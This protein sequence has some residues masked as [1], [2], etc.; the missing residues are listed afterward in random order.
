MTPTDLVL[1][2]IVTVSAIVGLFRGLLREAIAVFTWVAALWFAWHFGPSL[3]PSLGGALADPSVRPWA[4]R[5]IIFVGVLF[6]GAAIGW[7]AAYFVQLSIFRGTDRLLGFAFGLVRGIVA[8]G[9]LVIVGQALDLDR[10]EW[11]TRAKLAPFAESTANSLR[12]IVGDDPFERVE[13]LLTSS[14]A[15]RAGEG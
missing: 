6:V 5:A 11:W 14:A 7:V 8:I 12:A 4:A 2:A 15:S 10:D 3:E 13:E 9:V 1:I